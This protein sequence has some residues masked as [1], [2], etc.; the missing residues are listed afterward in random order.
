MNNSKKR[1]KSTDPDKAHANQMK[2]PLD[3]S[4]R[5][6]ILKFTFDL[7]DPVDT[8]LETS[9]ASEPD[10]NDQRHNQNENVQA[11]SHQSE[12]EDKILEKND[13]D[14]EYN[15][16][17][18]LDELPSNFNFSRPKLRMER[19]LSIADISDEIVQNLT[20]KY[21]NAN[22]IISADCDAI[23]DDYS[24]KFKAQSQ[25]DTNLMTKTHAEKSFDSKKS[26]MGYRDGS[27]ISQEKKINI[28]RSIL[29]DYNVETYIDKFTACDV[30][31]I[32][33]ES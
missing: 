10:A 12:P 6:P 14:D 7:V 21:N 25:P 5:Q 18:V 2:F 23:G 29:K 8:D 19:F 33:L 26:L 3:Y 17:D 27:G 11:T 31:E 13:E 4:N 16:D 28:I 20:Q 1:P 9:I 22:I 30:T 24:G 32:K 15:E